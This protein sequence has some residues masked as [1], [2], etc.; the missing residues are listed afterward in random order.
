MEQQ[1]RERFPGISCAYMDPEGKITTECYGF[2]E[3]EN[4]VPVD[5]NTIFPACSI[6]KF[7]TAM[8]LMKLQEQKV[9]DIHL[10][11]NGRKIIRALPH[12]AFPIQRIGST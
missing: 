5:E 12:P 3:K 10:P 7:I 8:C 4:R 9:L 2:A 1:I 6:S 11:V